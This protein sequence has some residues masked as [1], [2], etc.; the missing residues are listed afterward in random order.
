MAAKIVQDDDVAGTKRGHQDPLDVGSKALSIDRGVEDPWR[1]DPIMAQGSQKRH[2]FP[3]A[4]G[5]LGLEPRAPRCPSSKRRHGGLG[6][7]LID[8]NQALRGDPPLILC[9]LRPPAGDVGTIL[10]AGGHG[11]F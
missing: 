4:A 2:G 11:F 7:G 3:A 10:F 5:D 1:V 9:P 6:P 8:E